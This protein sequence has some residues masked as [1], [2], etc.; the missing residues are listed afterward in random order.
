MS[1]WEGTGPTQETSGLLTR[2]TPESKDH[3]GHRVPPVSRPNRHAHNG[4]SES[5]YG[6]PPKPATLGPTFPK[7]LTGDTVERHAEHLTNPAPEQRALPAN[8]AHRIKPS[9][10]KIDTLALGCK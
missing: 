6:K 9:T 7:H 10:L 5:G 2:D 4:V 1:L 3:G 8:R